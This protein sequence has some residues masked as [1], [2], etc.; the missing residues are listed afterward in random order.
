MLY[1]LDRVSK[2]MYLGE[3][4]RTDQIGEFPSEFVNVV[5]PLP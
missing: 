5:V 2:K 3:N 4:T 1:L